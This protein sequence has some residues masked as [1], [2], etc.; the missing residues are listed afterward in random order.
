MIRLQ[1]K[2]AEDTVSF[3]NVLVR[4]LS[5]SDYEQID[6]DLRTVLQMLQTD[7]ALRMAISAVREA[8]NMDARQEAN[9]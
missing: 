3:L 8:S 5:A 1:K 7:H 2:W 6:Y 4:N 9:K